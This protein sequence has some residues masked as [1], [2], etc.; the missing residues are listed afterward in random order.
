MHP[1]PAIIRVVVLAS[2]MVLGSTSALAQTDTT[3]P[4]VPV[5]K[6]RPTP[7]RP[8]AQARRDSIKPDTIRGVSTG[9]VAVP[10]APV[11]PTPKATPTP[12]PVAATPKV[13]TPAPMPATPVTKYL[14]GNTGLFVGFGGALAVP[15]N[16][17][18]NMGYQTSYGFAVPF[19]WRPVK[20]H[21]G[22]RGFF[23]YDQA[24]AHISGAANPLPAETGSA[25][26]PKIYTIAGDLL[27]AFP[28]SASARDGRGLTLYAI[29]GGGVY[30]F[31]G[32]GGTDPLS[33][34]LGIDEIG[35][36]KRNVH[37]WGVNAG[38]GLEWGLGPT[39][40]FFESRL[41]N[42]FTTKNAAET[43]NLRWIPIAA[44]VTVR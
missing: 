8:T 29:G 43:N 22:I 41:V 13:S 24:H 21:F 42:V 30:L 3:R 32:F 36:S 4:R 16:H 27:Y 7:A 33:A 2:A 19:G 39:A 1:H 34:T 9:E 18:S 38:G 28:L 40:I 14:F 11:T 6:E 35:S 10:V 26:D 20:Q 31:R 12:E 5:V 23:G 15:Y 37:K 17:F 25:P 44:G